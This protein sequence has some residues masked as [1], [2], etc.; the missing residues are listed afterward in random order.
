MPPPQ[1]VL[2]LT[3]ESHT[4]VRCHVSNFIAYSSVMIVTAVISLLLFVFFH[5]PLVFC[6][7]FLQQ[8]KE[9]HFKDVLRDAALRFQQCALCVQNTARCHCAHANVMTPMYITEGQPSFRIP[10]FTEQ[11][12]VQTTS[13]GISQN[14]DIK[15]VKIQTQIH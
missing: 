13:Q 6:R 12:H 9:Q 14:S 4:T 8:E 5:W 3:V 7:Y 1:Q 2:D 10:M 15:C 11:H